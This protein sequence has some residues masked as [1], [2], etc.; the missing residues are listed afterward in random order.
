MCVFLWYA[1]WK[2]PLGCSCF[3]VPFNPH[4]EAYGTLS[5]AEDALPCYKGVCKNSLVQVFPDPRSIAQRRLSSK[6]TP[7]RAVDDESCPVRK[8]KEG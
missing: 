6:E 3:H 1:F 2:T 8:H 5:G 7:Y 4:V